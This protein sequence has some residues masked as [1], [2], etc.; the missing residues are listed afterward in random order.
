MPNTARPYN[1]FVAALC[2]ACS[3]GFAS[4]AP[5]HIYVCVLVNIYALLEA[6]VPDQNVIPRVRKW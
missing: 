6:M 4:S 2:L 1:E 3:V 5:C